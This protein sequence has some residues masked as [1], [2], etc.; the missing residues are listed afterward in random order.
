VCFETVTVLE[1]KTSESV[2]SDSVHL[3]K[4][5]KFHCRED[6]T[7]KLRQTIAVPEQVAEVIASQSTARRGRVGIHRE[8]SMK[9]PPS[10]G[11][12]EAESELAQA[13]NKFHRRASQIAQSYQT[14]SS[15]EQMREADV[16]Q[17]PKPTRSIFLPSR[18][19]ACDNSQPEK[20]G[21]SQPGPVWRS[22]SSLASDKNT[23]LRP[24]SV[25][26]SQN[27]QPTKVRLTTANAM[28]HSIALGSSSSDSS[29]TSAQESSTY[30]R[31]RASGEFVHSAEV[32][33]C[34]EAYSSEL[35][36]SGKQEMKRAV[37]HNNDINTR[38]PSNHNTSIVQPGGK[39]ESMSLIH[40]TNPLMHW[41]TSALCLPKQEPPSDPSISKKQTPWSTM[42]D[43]TVTSSTSLL[44]QQSIS[45]VD[46]TS[47]VDAHRPSAGRQL[48]ARQK[49]C[50]E[51]AD[52]HVRS[53]IMQLL[54][55]SS[56]A[57]GKVDVRH[58]M[59]GLRSCASWMTD[60][61]GNKLEIKLK[62]S[63]S[64]ALKP[65]RPSTS[66]DDTLPA[67]TSA[68]LGHKRT[69]S[70]IDSSA[71][72]PPQQKRDSPFARR[73]RVSAES[74]YSATSVYQS[75][76][77]QVADIHAAG[78]AEYIQSL[79][80]RKAVTQKKLP[81]SMAATGSRCEEP[82]WLAL[83][84]QKK[85]RWTEGSAMEECYHYV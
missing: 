84:R 72:H 47:E 12:Q 1:D 54:S 13:F 82:S 63:H 21:L 3:W 64:I 29:S 66:T 36:S 42:M 41:E 81:P 17:P 38:S 75:N 28:K 68:L 5:P 62:K 6:D 40:N 74:C 65:R 2:Y 11:Q 32:E 71:Y 49:S 53:A 50:P 56:D 25:T 44:N 23:I 35:R 37:E 8:S 39:T 33:K 34:S 48:F 67:S 73:D 24:L 79:K 30:V 22:M 57:A 20:S 27:F 7:T 69:T 77:A 10:S 60:A 19:L 45:I 9:L 58:S 31:N 18:N 14:A 26:T 4:P 59:D 78:H 83:A 76:R 61:S 80:T 55:K 70:I 15:T 16:Q 51:K 43:E 85:Q 46:P 52:E